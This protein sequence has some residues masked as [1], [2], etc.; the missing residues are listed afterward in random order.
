MVLEPLAGDAIIDIVQVH[1]QIDRSA[2]AALP[3]RFPGAAA[4][5]PRFIGGVAQRR[6]FGEP[7]SVSLAAR[8]PKH[9]PSNLPSR[10][11]VLNRPD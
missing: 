7:G 1:H 5:E 10:K 8:G 2:T 3:S 6:P 11:R 9:G 4:K